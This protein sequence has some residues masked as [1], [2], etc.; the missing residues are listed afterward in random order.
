MS[1]HVRVEL[2]EAD[3]KELQGIAR[4]GKERARV[5]RRAQ[6]LLMADQN[7]PGYK[8]QTQIVNGLEVSG[9]TVSSTC[10]RY[11]LEGLQAALSEKPRKG[12][13]MPKMTGEVEAQLLLA[14]CS[15]PPE[16]EARWTLALLQGR[17]IELKLVESISRMAISK[18]LKKMK[19]SLGA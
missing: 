12:G 5:I 8:T 14:A 19:L 15:H 17:L 2:T 16:G 3:R 10:R 18:T 7:R 13:Q 9:G 4:R 6:I 1:K 11:A